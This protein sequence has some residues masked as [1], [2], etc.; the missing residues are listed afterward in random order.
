MATLTVVFAVYGAIGGG[1][2]EN[3]SQA[4]DVTDVLQTA[5]NANDGIVA[6]NNSTMGG[7]PS[8]GN[9]KHFGAIVALDGVN[10]AFACQEDQTIDFYHTIPPSDQSELV[11]AHEASA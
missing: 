7:D 9:K 5:I 1:G 4:V 11:T 8:S 3:D 2:N 6:I 10:R